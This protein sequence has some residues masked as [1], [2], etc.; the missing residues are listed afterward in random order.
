VLVRC[1]VNRTTAVLHDRFDAERVKRTFEAGEITLAS[2]V[3]TMLVRLREA[4][5]RTAPNLRAIALGGG[6]IPAGLLEWA[7]ETGIPVTPSTA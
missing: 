1:A 5:L 3:P 7:Q 2:L 6:P 4:G